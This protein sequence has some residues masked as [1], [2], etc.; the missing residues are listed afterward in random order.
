MIRLSAFADEISDDLD[1]QIAVL[2]AEG[3]QLL[4]LRSVAGVNVLDL[5]DEQVE[6]IRSRLVAGG[7]G[8]AAIASPLGKSAIGE[9]FER[10][11]AGLDR[12]IELAH[13]FDTR[14]IRIFSFY[15]EGCSGESMRNE[16]V[17]RLR[18]MAAGAGESDTILVHENDKGLYGDTIAR[19]VE[20]M[21]AVD[22]PALRVALD[23]AN[24]IQCGEKPFPD[25]YEALRPWLAYV[26]VKDAR[27]DGT[28]VEAGRGEAR[29]LE[30]LSALRRDGY[31]GVFALEPHLA[32]EG[33][34]R[35]FSG[36]DRFREASRAFGGLLGDMDWAHE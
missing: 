29:W 3:I 27:H 8:V 33:Q 9:P 23:P 31:E 18:A 21:E 36:P 28:V 32:A 7:I 5:T 35:G 6:Q 14:V 25:A 11:V 2:L 16:V 12:A 10:V 26:H 24:F 13:I 1:E 4:D 30:L 22:S 20:L 17:T 19:C 34:Y 15:P